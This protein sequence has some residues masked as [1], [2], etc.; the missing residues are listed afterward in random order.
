MTAR[1]QFGAELKV[2]GKAKAASNGTTPVNF[3]F[4]S[5]S[6]LYLPNVTGF[7]SNMR[8]VALF[9]ASRA[10]GTTDTITFGVQ[11]APDSSS[12][13]GTPATALTTT[14]T[15]AG[16]VGAATGD[17]YALVAVQLQANRPWLR[18]TAVSSGATDAM[19]LQVTVIGIPVG[20]I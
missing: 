7:V 19:V 8:I 18:F 5:P 2:L 1:M 17:A 11:D 16:L 6:D 4:G 10:S 3:S 15:G 14:A 12:A 9:D 13:I 20:L